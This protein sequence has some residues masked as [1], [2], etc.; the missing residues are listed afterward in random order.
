MRK[1]LSLVAALNRFSY[2][3]DFTKPE[4]LIPTEEDVL[5]DKYGNVT[6]EYNSNI[7]YIVCNF[8]DPKQV[9]IYYVVNFTGNTVVKSSNCLRNPNTKIILKHMNDMTQ[10]SPL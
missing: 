1:S 5:I 2:S 8:K 3:I 7:Q 4:R 6:D 10:Q 9:E